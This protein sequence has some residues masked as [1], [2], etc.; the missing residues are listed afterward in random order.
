MTEWIDFKTAARLLGMTSR[1]V[2]RRAER[3]RWLTEKPFPI[4]P[5]GTWR[6]RKGRGGGAEISIGLLPGDV[7]VRLIQERPASRRRSPSKEFLQIVAGRRLVE[8]AT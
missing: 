2:Q 8:G 7:R 6:R 1:G 3:E 4:D 5:N